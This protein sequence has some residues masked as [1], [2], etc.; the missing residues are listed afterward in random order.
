MELRAPALFDNLII[1]KKV[2]MELT[3]IPNPDYRSHPAYGRLFGRPSIILRAKALRRFLPQ[4][5]RQL[6]RTISEKPRPA[7]KIIP[8]KDDLRDCPLL[9]KLIQDGIVAIRLSPDEINNVRQLAQDYIDSLQK[10]KYSIPVGKRKFGDK[11]SAIRSSDNPE[12]YKKILEIFGHHKIIT[13]FERYRGTALAINNIFVHISDPDDTDWRHRFAD[14][15]LP[16]S[17]SVYM[18]FDSKIQ[19][20]KCL[21]YLTEVMA[22]N[23]PFCHIQGSNRIKIG[24]LEYITRKAND[25]SGLDNCDPKT[26]RLFNALPKIFQRKSE[27]GNDLADSDPGTKAMLSLER[28]Y[29]TD[30]GNLILFD[31]DSLHRGGMIK[32]GQRIM[33]QI[34]F[35]RSHK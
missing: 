1:S 3:D 7:Y 25:K 11:V 23:G 21:L 13:T 34:D 16:D 27:F 15:N 30:Q 22:D 4:F 14:I 12:L 19:R 24:F 6:A 28:Q 5:F 33:L 17:K 31:T 29:T 2:K 20:M 35:V 32:Q 26:R 10:H 18:H 8:T 9:S